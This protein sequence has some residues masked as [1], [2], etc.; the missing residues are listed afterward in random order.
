MRAAKSHYSSPKCSGLKGCKGPGAPRPAGFW[1]GE[2]AAFCAG[3]RMQHK[4][5][6]R[7][8]E[9]DGI[10]AQPQRG[11]SERT[12]PAG[13]DDLG[14]PR[15]LP[16]LRQEGTTGGGSPPKPS[17]GD[18]APSAPAPCLAPPSW[19]VP[20]LRWYPTAAAAPPARRAGM[21][22]PSLSWLPQD[23]IGGGSC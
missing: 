8:E 18:R 22:L 1:Q 19:G 2:R 14:T 10:G 20:P 5:C 23:L 16:E 12:P 13:S 7:H 4:A 21:L 9:H 11:C 15:L 6:G 3:A 17:P